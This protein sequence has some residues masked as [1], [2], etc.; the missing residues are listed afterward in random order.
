MIIQNIKPDLYKLPIIK[1]T[2]I[3]VVNLLNKQFNH[4]P[5]LITNLFGLLNV[6]PAI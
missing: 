1:N 2:N 6:N 4:K 5:N 3:K